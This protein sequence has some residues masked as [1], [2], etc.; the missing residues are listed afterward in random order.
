MPGKFVLSG[1]GLRVSGLGPYGSVSEEPPLIRI[2]LKRAKRRF[3][4]AIKKKPA[5]IARQIV[6]SRP[7]SVLVK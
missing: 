6:G 2:P 5:P 1:Q 7:T 3:P 4:N